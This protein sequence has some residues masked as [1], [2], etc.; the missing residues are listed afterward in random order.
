[1]NVA[2]I[3]KRKVGELLGKLQDRFPGRLLFANVALTRA[4][5]LELLQMY[6]EKVHVPYSDRIKAR[7]EQFFMTTSDIDDPL[8]VTAMLRGLWGDMTP[9]DQEVVWRYLDLFEKLA[10][11]SESETSK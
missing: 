3:F 6:V 9:K 5:E 11:R 4:K 8:N 10:C 7:D 2:V 1:M